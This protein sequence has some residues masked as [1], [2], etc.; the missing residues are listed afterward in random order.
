MV[1][2]KEAPAGEART[3]V[4]YQGTLVAHTHWDRAWYLPFQQFRIRLVRLIDRLLDLLDADPEFRCF[5]LDG[6]MIVVEDYLEVRPE[7]RSEVER[8]A[9][10][11]R[12]LIGPWYVL[13]DEYLVSHEAL[14]RNLERGMEAATG[15]GGAT[16]IGYIPD[17]F[18]HIA[19][20]PQIL[21]GF[22]VTNAVFWR[23]I[24]DEARDLGSEFWWAAPDGTRVLGIFLAGKD[25]Y[26]QFNHL[27]YPQRGDVWGMPFSVDLALQQIETGI[28]ELIPFANTPNLLLMCGVDH[29][30]ANPHLP[31]V[32]QAANERLPNL[33]LR[34][35]SV[36]DHIDAV[37]S[38]GVD[39]RHYRGELRASTFAFALQQVY[40]SRIYL[41]QRNSQCQTLLEA[42]AEPFTTFAALLG[43]ES[44]GGFLDLAWRELMKNHPHDDICGCS[45]DP[46]HRQMMTRFEE[47][48]QIGEVLVRDALRYLTYRIA[49]PEGDPMPLFVFNPGSRPHTGVMAATL[50]FPPDRANLAEAFSIRDEN[51]ALVPHEEIGRQSRLVMEVNRPRRTVM[52]DI[53]L[54]LPQIPA[55]GY[56]TLF[57]GPP[58][59]PPATDIRVEGAT[60]EN[61]FLR[62]TVNQDGTLQVVD[63]ETGTT[64]EGLHAIEDT[65]DAGD[66]YTY[67]PAPHP[68][69]LTHADAR[70]E[71]AP[72]S[73]GP[74]RAGF[75]ISY[76]LSLPRQL[77]PARERR[78]DEYVDCTITT[79]VWLGTGE[80]RLDFV[81]RVT[82]TARD[83]RLRVLFPT[84]LATDTVSVEAHFD[85][86]QRPVQLPEGRGWREPPSP[87]AHQ[88]AFVDVSDGRAGL[89]IFNRGLPEYEAMAREDGVLIALTLLRCVGWLSRSDLLTRPGP[90]G[91][92]L[93]TPEAQCLGE[94]VFEYAIRPHAG[95]W[96]TI[97]HDAHAFTAPCTLVTDRSTE[98]VLPSDAQEAA[99]VVWEPLPRESD[100]DILPLHA[101][102]VGLEPEELVL[103]AARTARDGKGVVVRCYN[104]SGRAVSGRLKLLWPV[105]RAG[106][107]NLLEENTGAVETRDSAVLFDVPPKGIVSIRCEV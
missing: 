86:L 1:V 11:G 28:Q 91:P 38:A 90:A 76:V 18:G 58:A 4:T 3:G 7:R 24:G 12:L 60:M 17:S 16:L 45:V 77:S 9:R 31:E 81:T 29:E 41:K 61:A 40:S 2:G 37:L 85:V 79:D 103:S 93:E 14:I 30:E 5:T 8:H 72:L 32:V 15:F 59:P 104:P 34:M 33:R 80:R 42:Y 83:H 36:K 106:A 21:A 48:E 39:F 53:V 95:G 44:Q 99:P 87:T 62:A 27:G 22:G 54:S 10:S 82:N 71:V 57:V 43:A 6:Q 100:L 92:S 26:G 84:P 52:V 35:G 75:R 55:C 97:V 96:E 68:M 50:A 56:R 49:T 19:Q 89:A 88:R 78:S 64:Y 107:V 63:L 51:G 47:V 102:F 66:E 65:E 98:G 73:L 46:V 13:A 74:V 69:K 94:Y 25:G 101:S 105:K 20:L 70:V 67:S 23:G